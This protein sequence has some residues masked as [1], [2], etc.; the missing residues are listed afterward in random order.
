MGFLGMLED[1]TL[2]PATLW[3]NRL[4]NNMYNHAYNLDFNRFGVS[5]S[6]R[7]AFWY[8]FPLRCLV[9]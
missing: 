3:S 5:T 9:R 6:G 1:E 2:N 7:N 8:G 4:A